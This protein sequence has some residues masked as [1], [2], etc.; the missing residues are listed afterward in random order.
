M[1]YYEQVECDNI[2][3]PHSTDKKKSDWAIKHIKQNETHI[4]SELSK[5][6]IMHPPY[7][8]SELQIVY[9]PECLFLYKINDNFWDLGVIGIEKENSEYKYHIMQSSRL[10]L[11]SQYTAY[12]GEL[13]QRF[14]SAAAEKHRVSSLPYAKKKLFPLFSGADEKSRILLDYL[15]LS[16][17]RPQDA[18][19]VIEIDLDNKAG[20]THGRI[21]MRGSG[22]TL[23]RFNIFGAYVMLLKFIRGVCTDIELS[24]ETFLDFG[25]VFEKVDTDIG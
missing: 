2:F 21:S 13:V 19:K 5:E 7:T 23:V 9:S 15:K 16:D 12:T 20:Y 24:Y 14:R 8:P 1:R 17:I 25:S 18:H 10:F 4:I 11:K 6:I 22:V 3:S